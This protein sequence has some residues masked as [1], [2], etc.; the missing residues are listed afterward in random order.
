MTKAEYLAWF[1]EVLQPTEPTFRLV[2]PDKL[3]FKLTEKSFTIGQQLS[4]IP[5]A[6]AFM[7]KVINQEE[8]PFKSV[9]EILVANRHHHSVTVEQ[10]IE[11]LNASMATFKGAVEKLSDEEFQR[12]LVDTPQKGRISYWRYGA[13]ALEHHL[14]HL[15]ELHLCLKMLGADVNTKTLYAG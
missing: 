15:M 10:G 2:P 12:G 7:A 4:H 6:F 13:F 14:H 3:N 9:R 5:A 1:D 8:L 11:H